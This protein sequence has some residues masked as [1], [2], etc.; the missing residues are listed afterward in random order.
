VAAALPD[1][2][3]LD[4]RMKG[5]DGLEV[6]RQLKAKAVTRHIPVILIS[7]FADVK[8]WVAGLQLGAADYI[9]KP[10]QA[11]ELL[12]R[13][14]VQLALSRATIALERQAE[15]LRM[16][17]EQLQLEIT[18]R[19]QMQEKLK[20]MSIHDA[21]TGLYNYGFFEEEMS[22]FGR[23]RDFPVSIVMADLN[24]LKKV[25]DG[26]GHAAGDALIQRAAQ[27]FKDAFRAADIIARVGGDEFA[28]LLPDTDTASAQQSL[29]RVKSAL[30]KHNLAH[31][32]A[33]V[34]IA[35]G[36]STAMQGNA[37]KDTIKEADARMY[38][39]KQAGKMQRAS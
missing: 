2:I 33:P 4:M 31:G 34:S 6:C 7:A 8:E 37:L 13:V 12:A 32:G 27:V 24:G 9:N 36:V 17:N 39:E 18:E 38:E 21:L 30:S 1:L 20:E 29:L 22:R 28:I 15:A 5:M 10:F 25:N 23:G 19:K 11:E 3:L 26:D 14:K 16:A 35:L